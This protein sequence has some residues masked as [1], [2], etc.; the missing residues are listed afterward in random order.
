[1]KTNTLRHLQV[2]NREFKHKMQCKSSESMPEVSPQVYL[3]ARGRCPGADDDSTPVH[4]AV[5]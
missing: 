1:M 4:V 5:R 3:L 2:M